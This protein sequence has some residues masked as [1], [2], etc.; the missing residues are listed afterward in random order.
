MFVCNSCGVSKEVKNEDSFFTSYIICDLCHGT[1]EEKS[2]TETT[3]AEPLPDDLGD[4]DDDD[5]SME[6]VEKYMKIS[7]QKSLDIDGDLRTW[8]LIEGVPDAQSRIRYRKF[9][10]ELGGIIPNK[11]RE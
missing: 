4:D 9:F 8:E 11:K 2:T 6:E 3:D 5:I 10:Q 7:I 1:M